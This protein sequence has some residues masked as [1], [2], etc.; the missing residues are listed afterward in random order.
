MPISTVDAERIRMAVS[1]AQSGDLDPLVAVI[2]VLDDMR[3]ETVITDPMQIMDGT[4]IDDG[5]YTKAQEIDHWLHSDEG[6]IESGQALAHLTQALQHIFPDTTW[7]D[8]VNDTARRVL[9]YWQEYVPKPDI[10]FNFTTFKAA[11]SQVIL[12]ADIE[13]TSLCVHH[14]MPFT[15]KVHIAYKPR[16]TVAGL[17][18][19]PRLVRY[20][21]RRPQVQETLTEQLVTDIKHRLETQDVM[22]MV[23]ARHTCVSARGARL[24]NGVMRTSLPAGLFLISDMA[25][26]EFFSLLAR[27]GV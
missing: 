21:A 25:R 1:N 13:F 16:D 12:I 7:D 23:E 22:V 8:S 6:L 27:N 10:D 19:I 3:N 24:H 11:K 20:W 2:K 15:G 5:A 4:V 14:L 9:A 17:S 26:A 18:K